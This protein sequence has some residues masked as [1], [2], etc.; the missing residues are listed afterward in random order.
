ML[1]RRAAVVTAIFALIL[2]GIPIAEAQNL[3][4]IDAYGTFKAPKNAIDGD[5]ATIAEVTK[6]YRNEYFL[7]LRFASPSILRNIKVNFEGDRPKDYFIEM[8]SDAVGWKPLDLGEKATY[9]RVRIPAGDGTQAFKI[10]EIEANSEVAPAEA[11]LMTAMKVDG[12]ETTAAT[13]TV[14]FTKPVRLS[15]AYGI[16]PHPE[17]LKNFTEY[18]SFQSSYQIQLRDLIEGQDYYVRVKAMSAQEELY[19]SDDTNYLHFRLLG[20]PPLKVVNG[21]VGYVNP[22]A[23]SVVFQTNIPS[24]CV[25]YFGE[26]DNF[27]QIISQ[28]GYDTRHVFEFKDLLPQH[29]YSYMAFLTDHRGLNQVLPRTNVSTAEVNIA[30]NKKVIA[31]TFTVQREPGWQ[32]GSQSA[33]ETTLQKLTDGRDDYFNGMAHSGD[34]D[35][36]DQFATIDLG[37]VYTIES[38][39]VIWRTLAYPYAYEMF[40]SLDNKEWKKCAH[41]PSERI[42]MGRTIRSH[43]GDPLLVTGGQFFDQTKARYV[44]LLIPKGTPYFKR[45]KEWRNVDLAE[46]L[47]Y[48][49]GEY[50][51]LK[52]I[53]EEEWHP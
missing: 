46:I 31:G 21:G 20:T 17:A 47:I 51:D 23:F 41:I 4:F 33:G 18:T 43:G 32:G 53:V 27:S 8:S 7:I 13:V 1:D 2:T 35:R 39:A 48:P 11:F 45:H 44:K 37:R 16:E 15:L 40:A 25:M 9:M 28:P 6:P 34:I 19:V 10:S 36:E 42:G 12:I 50:N 22:L 26:P 29:V 14:A 5:R 24:H 38:H 30:R 3:P 52:K 49:G